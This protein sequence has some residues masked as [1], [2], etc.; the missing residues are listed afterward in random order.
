[1]P[2]TDNID[3]FKEEMVCKSAIFNGIDFHFFA[4]GKC[5]TSGVSL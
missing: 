5:S 2:V 3:F 1:M 4:F